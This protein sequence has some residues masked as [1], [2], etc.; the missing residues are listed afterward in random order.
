M[1][2]ALSVDMLNE[3]RERARQQCMELSL[4]MIE[5][6]LNPDGSTYGDTNLSRPQRVARF[7]QDAESGALDI[8]KVQSPTIYE[9]YVRDYVHDVRDV[10]RTMNNA[11][12]AAPEMAGM[13][14]G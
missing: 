6:L 10:L 4:A 13:L 1:P 3:V 2:T 9:R 14:N 11:G 8:L 12:A 7:I 5:A